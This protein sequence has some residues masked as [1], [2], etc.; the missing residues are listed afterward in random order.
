MKSE[1]EWTISRFD[2][3]RELAHTSEERSMTAEATWTLEEVDARSTRV[4]QALDFEM[5]P[6]FRPLRRLLEA[7]FAKR[8]SNRETTRMLQDVK[9]IAESRAATPSQP[10]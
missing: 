5:M 3:P 8:M 10:S 7:V 4:T 9:R 6:R 1:S 2:P